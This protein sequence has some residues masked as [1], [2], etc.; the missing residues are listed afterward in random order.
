MNI[1]TANGKQLRGDLIKSAI[2]RYD[3]APV[4][5]TFEGEF[6]IDDDLRKQFAEGQIITVNGDNYRIIKPVG[7]SG[8]ESQGQHGTGAMHVIALLDA[9]H[10]V[11][12]VRQ[13]AIIK[14]NAL[15][16]EIYRAAGASIKPVDGDF[17]AGRFVCMVGET[18][19]F[20]IARVLQEEGGVVRWKSGKLQFLRL[21]DLF[22]QKPF[23]T[24]PD[25]AS[26][27]AKSDFLSRHEI[28][29]FYSLADDGAVIYGNREKARSARFVPGKNQQQLI[30]MSRCLVQ[31][32]VSKIAFNPGIR[33]GDLMAIAGSASLAVVT[34]A[35]VF[36]SGTD[37]SGSNQYTKLWM[38][39]IEA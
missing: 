2:T 36:Q 18:P 26:E 14:E 38:S 33:A 15:L 37:G 25:N 5:S 4:P 34:A 13:K 30:N 8:R 31:R 22:K 29:S 23:M 39:A 24:L 7:G 3:L 10:A 21:A 17:K 9:C 35:H 16:T 27:N 19:S 28:P 32:K 11:T 20:H 1:V 12:F 6:R